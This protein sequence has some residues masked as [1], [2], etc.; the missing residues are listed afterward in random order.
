ARS[1]DGD[2]VADGG[3]GTDT[4]VRDHG[5][6]AD[7][8]RSAHARAFDARSLLETHA[9]DELTLG[10]DSS[11]DRGFEP[12]VEHRGVGDEKV[13]FLSGVEPPRREAGELH[14]AAELDELAD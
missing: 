13:G 5:S 8:D 2:P 4:R 14:F 3:E 9:T 7:D 6:L 10:V 11:H 12:I 1:R